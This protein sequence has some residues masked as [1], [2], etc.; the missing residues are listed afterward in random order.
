MKNKVL[1]VEDDAVLG[2]VLVDN[3]T[4][5][6]FQVDHVPEGRAA[7]ESC[8]RNCPDLILLDLNLPDGDG[9][10]LIELFRH[11]ASTPVIVLTAR[12]QKADKLKGLESGADDY[13]TKPFDME[14]LL[15]RV[16]V[17]LRRSHR[18]TDTLKIGDVTIDFVA[19]AAQRGKEPLRLT[20]KEFEMLHYL[21]Q[22]QGRVVFRDELLKAVWGYPE[23]PLTRSVDNAIARLRKKIEPDL[24]HPRHIHTVHGDGYRLTI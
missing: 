23:A 5:E 12:G 17:V 3:L 24:Q 18:E 7:L 10:Q 2:R 16:H 13:I 15:A 1:V 19:R 4:F 6:G 11:A 22:H 20:D 21:A 9:L 8:R 14:E